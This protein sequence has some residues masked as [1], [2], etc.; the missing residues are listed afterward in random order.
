MSHKKELLCSLWA[1]GL[2]VSGT[3]RVE[4]QGFKT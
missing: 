4:T 3:F 2:G 1:G